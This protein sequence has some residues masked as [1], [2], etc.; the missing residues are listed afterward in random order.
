MR[1]L[2]SLLWPALFTCAAMAILVSLGVWQLQ[3]LAWKEGVIAQIESRA[4]AAPQPLPEPAEWP[5]LRPD[6]YEYRHVH[7]DGRFENDKEALVFRPSGGGSGIKTPGYLVLTPLRLPSGAYVIVNR[8]FVPMDRKEPQ[9]RLAGKIEGETRV[10]GLMRQP[11][12]RNA[13]TPADN[14]AS[15]Q[16]FTRDP[17]LIAAH[18]GLTQAAPFSIDAD[19][20]PVPGGWPKGGATEL[21]FPNNHLSYALTWFGLALALLGVFVVFA[22]QKR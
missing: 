11:E 13:F 8:G 4:K 12:S 17:A 3:R 5:N 6:S 14:P 19:A 7:L 15:G 22:W 10:I 20:E 2:A 18:F 21:S 1:R 16:Y 9:G